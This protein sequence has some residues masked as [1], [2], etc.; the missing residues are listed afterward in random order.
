MSG[1]PSDIVFILKSM[2][3]FSDV[4]LIITDRMGR[5]HSTLTLYNLKMGDLLNGPGRV[6]FGMV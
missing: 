4:I 3:R 2:G 5:L 6:T 1:D